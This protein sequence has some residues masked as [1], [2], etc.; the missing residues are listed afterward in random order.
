MHVYTHNIV[1]KTFLL[2]VNRVFDVTII[3]IND[4]KQSVTKFV[5]MSHCFSTIVL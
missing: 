4:T 3:D 2:E 5:V 1:P